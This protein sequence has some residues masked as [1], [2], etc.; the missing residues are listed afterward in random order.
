MIFV[1]H[2]IIDLSPAT[3]WRRTPTCT[4]TSC[5]TCKCQLARSVDPIISPLRSR[6][7]TRRRY[8]N[9]MYDEALLQAVHG[10]RL[11]LQSRY[12]S[13]TEPSHHVRRDAALAS[14]LPAL[15]GRWSPVIPCRLRRAG[16]AGHTRGGITW[17][18]LMA[19]QQSRARLR[20]HPP[21]RG[22][23][24]G[25][26]IAQRPPSSPALSGYLL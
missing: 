14:A 13:C 26:A 3:A 5:T 1:H 23:Y 22:F 4:T 9:H 16:L 10:L 21:C 20:R 15:A 11:Q 25:D 8:G 7:Q 24:R 18:T 6:K 19:R 2:E 12:E 17:S